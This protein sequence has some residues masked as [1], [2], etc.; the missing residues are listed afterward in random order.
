VANKFVWS[1]ATGANDG[2]KWEDAYT[3]LARDWGAEAGFTPGT[4]FIYV[5]SVHAESDAAGKIITGS[6]S[7]DTTAM[8]RI[9]CVVGAATGTSPGNLA[10][11][12][13]VTTTGA[14]DLT[15]NEGLYIYGVDFFCANDLGLA[16]GFGGTDH[17]MTLE[18]CRLEHTS[19]TADKRIILGPDGSAVSPKITFIN[20]DIDFAAATQSIQLN[21]CDLIWKGGTVDYDVDVLFDKFGFSSGGLV[22]LVG[23]D[24]ST[25]ASSSLVNG[26]VNV[27]WQG[28]VI[29]FS[30]CK[31]PSSYSL[32]T[33]TMGMPAFRVE[34]FHCQVG[35]DADPAY[36]MEIQD[37]RGKIV[38]DTARYRTGGGKDV[39]RTNPISWDFDTTGASRRQYPGHPLVGPP[40]TAWTDGDATT[41]HTYRISFA[42]DA[43]IQDDDFWIE[44]E[45]PNDAATDS[46]AVI[47]TTRVAP[48]GTAANLPTDSGSTWTGSG[49]GTKQYAEVTYTPDKPGP[50]T[51]RCYMAKASDNIYVDPK[52][53]IDP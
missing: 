34:S 3:S 48:R 42:S 31:F 45:G 52:I 13:S 10:T 14:N 18:E 1:G 47:N 33:G 12:A 44:V 38:T 5:R 28:R 43:T 22:L 26:T 37:N 51:I 49:V 8:C 39:E 24:L 20:V 53:Q 32:V 19:A 50:V 4:D 16:A 41:A 15:I 35:T 30:R 46:M 40:I 36:Q 7:D 6:T 23:L 21:V 25:L 17:D 11:G 9:I 2:S 29:V 27:V